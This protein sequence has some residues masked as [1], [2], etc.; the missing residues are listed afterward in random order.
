MAASSSVTFG[1]NNFF[2]KDDAAETAVANRSL[3]DGGFGG[4]SSFGAIFFITH[5]APK[6]RVTKLVIARRI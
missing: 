1:A 4:S 2:T 5:A 6:S 3:R